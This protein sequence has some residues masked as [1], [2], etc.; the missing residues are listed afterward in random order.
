MYHC[1][2]PAQGGPSICSPG[3]WTVESWAVAESDV[4][5]I[6]KDAANA[7]RRTFWYIGDLGVIR[8][9]LQI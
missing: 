9:E 2:N 8:K 5:G 7:K 3:I 6:A 4:S 1:G